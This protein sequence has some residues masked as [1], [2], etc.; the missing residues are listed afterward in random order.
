LL[1]LFIG[2]LTAVPVNAMF[3]GNDRG[4]STYPYASGY[5][6]EYEPTYGSVIGRS[7]GVAG[8]SLGEG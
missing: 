6:P 2:V 7:S 8:R 1:E 4:V 5:D 3:A